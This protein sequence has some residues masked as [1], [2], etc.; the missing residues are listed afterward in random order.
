MCFWD[1]GI[2]PGLKNRTSL[3]LS[4]VGNRNR[5]NNEISRL[6]TAGPE[7]NVVMR[8]VYLL[9]SEFI[10]DMTLRGGSSGITKIAIYC[11]VS[12]LPDF[13][14]LGIEYGNYLWIES[15]AL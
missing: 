11:Y 14:S 8:V 4:A 15:Y 6:D 12:C 3:E 9:G 2:Q 5:S 1:A 10:L 7:L 13:S